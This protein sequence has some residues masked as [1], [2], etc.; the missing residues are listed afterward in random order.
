MLSNMC[1]RVCARPVRVVSVLL[2]TN[3]HHLNKSLFLAIYFSSELNSFER[4][5]PEGIGK[6]LGALCS[7]GLGAF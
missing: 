6:S 4:I 2:S 1:P 7:I 3:I 5:R